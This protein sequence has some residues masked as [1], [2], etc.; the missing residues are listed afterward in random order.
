[1]AGDAVALTV[2]PHDDGAVA[3]RRLCGDPLHLEIST[4][5]RADVASESIA[6]FTAIAVDAL[7]DDA[8]WVPTAAL[9]AEPRPR[10]SW[11]PL[12]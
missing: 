3:W 6:T 12:S 5:W 10:P 9:C 7:R 1:M 11:G 2:R 4:A 8:G